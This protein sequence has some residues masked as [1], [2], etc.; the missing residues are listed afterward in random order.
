M[1]W[2]GGSSAEPSGQLDAARGE[3]R[4]DAVVAGLAVDVGEVVGRR[5]RRW[6]G[7]SWSVRNSS[8]ISVHACWCTSAVGVS[9][10]SRSKSTARYG[11]PDRR[12]VDIDRRRGVLGRGHQTPT[13]RHADARCSDTR[14][15]DDGTHQQ[16]GEHGDDEQDEGL[17]G[18]RVG[19]GARAA[20]DRRACAPAA[21]SRAKRLY[22]AS[23]TATVG[24]R[25]L[26]EQDLAPRRAGEVPDAVD[27]RQAPWPRRR[28]RRRAAPTRRRST[29]AAPSARTRRRR[30]LVGPPRRHRR[31]ASHVSAT[32]PPTQMLAADTWTTSATVC[33]N[34]LPLLTVCPSNA[35]DS[36]SAPAPATATAAATGRA[37]RTEAA[38]APAARA[39]AGRDSRADAAAAPT[40]STPPPSRRS[41]SGGGV[42]AAKG[43]E[44]G[45]GRR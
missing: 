41:R 4:A 42:R 27:D 45:A 26:E 6:S 44:H 40:A 31:Q 10:P 14:G 23:A 36:T 21:G 16:A 3:E 43:V 5:V 18:E 8:N 22:A 19:D 28:R 20:W 7:P 33:T 17:G 15:S 13:L 24:A 38:A 32:T 39:A 2:P 9:T 25:Q 12:E 1:P 29:I 37:G 11:A 30:P 35:Y 34:R